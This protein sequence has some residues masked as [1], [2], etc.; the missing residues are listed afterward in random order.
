MAAID[1]ILIPLFGKTEPMFR[2][3]AQT[4]PYRSQAPIVCGIYTIRNPVTG[5]FYLGSSVDVYRRLRAHIQ[6]LRGR[7]HHSYRMQNLW[8]AKGEGCLEFCVDLLLDCRQEAL[9]IEHQILQTAKPEYNS[10][11]DAY[12]GMKGRS[13]TPE[14]LAKIIASK[15]G[16][17]WVRRNPVD[18]E[19]RAALNAQMSAA[20]MGVPRPDLLGRKHTDEIRQQLSEIVRARFARGFVNGRTRPVEF[21]GVRYVSGRDAAKALGHGPSWV[22]AQIKRGRGRYLDTNV[23]D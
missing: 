8:T 6:E 18:P 16:K 23:F 12:T 10:S 20:R 22:C 19:R 14:S 1:P 13:H 5:N 7:R 15:K 2:Y 3:T 17:T 11:T 4:L 21:D 9:A